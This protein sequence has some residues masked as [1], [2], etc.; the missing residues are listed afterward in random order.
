MTVTDEDIADSDKADSVAST[1][2]VPPAVRFPK[3]RTEFRIPSRFLKR[4]VNIFFM[5]PEAA[6]NRGLSGL[7]SNVMDWRGDERGE[8]LFVNVDDRGRAEN[9]EDTELDA[10]C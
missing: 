8:E 3:G 6:R 1:E 7:P 5:F 9:R 2:P 4:F 10:E